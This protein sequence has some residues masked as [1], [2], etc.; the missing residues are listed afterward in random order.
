M[1][2][3]PWHGVCMCVCGCTCRCA[4]QLALALAS[5]SR[6]SPCLS[7]S[8]ALSANSL[9]GQDRAGDRDKGQGQREF[10]GEVNDGDNGSGGDENDIVMIGY[11]D[12]RM[13][14][15]S[16]CFKM[17]RDILQGGGVIHA[18]R[19]PQQ[20]MMLNLLKQFSCL[21]L[22]PS[23]QVLLGLTTTRGEII[24]MLELLVCCCGAGN[25]L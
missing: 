14:I 7:A 20:P 23:Q 24:Q 16:G 25:V 22:L 4:S 19:P 12:D 21:L 10:G 3:H 6:R 2:V 8:R 18:P 17:G 1:W 9:T 15:L 13:F 11:S 5:A